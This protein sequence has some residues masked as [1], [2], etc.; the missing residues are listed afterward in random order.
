M[1]F[2]IGVLTAMVRRCGRCGGGL[3]LWGVIAV[4]MTTSA[5]T[6]AGMSRLQSSQRAAVAICASAEALRAAGADR[7]VRDEAERWCA[8]AIRLAAV[9]TETVAATLERAIEASQDAGVPV[10]DAMQDPDAGGPSHPSDAGGYPAPA[11]PPDDPEEK[12]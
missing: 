3:S 4:A 7:K 5:C 8:S 9:E 6:A 10:P 12:R 1:K 2:L 11:G